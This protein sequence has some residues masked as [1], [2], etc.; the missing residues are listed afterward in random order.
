MKSKILSLFLALSLNQASA[1][2]AKHTF[3]IGKD[4]FLLDGNPIVIRCGELHSARV[5]REYWQDRL[6]RMRAMGMNAVCAYLFWN[7]HEWEEGKYDWKGQADVAEFCR[8]AQAEGLLVV[9]RPGPYA[10][11]EWEMG[12]LPW[13]LLKDKDIEL[14]TR[15]PKFL[16]ASKSW[17]KEVGRELGPLQVTKGGPIVMVQVENEYGFYGD[18]KEYMTELARAT[19]EAGFDVPL[20]ACNPRVKIDVARIPE[21]FPVVNFGSDP[22]GAFKALREVLPEGPLMCGE[23]YPGWFDTWGY[24]HHLGNTKGYLSDLEYMLK[25]KGSFSIYMAHGGTSF[26]LWAG[27]DGPFKPD[28]S[29]YDYDA[30]ISEAGWIGEKFQKTR[31]LMSRYLEA[32]E[33]LPD[34]PANL[35]VMSVPEFSLEQSAAIFENLPTPVADRQ[36]QNMEMYDQGRGMILYRTTIPAGPEAML[37]TS[38]VH[39]F[40]WVFVDGRQIGILDRR[41]ASSKVTIPARTEPQTLDLLVE[42]MGRVN[43]GRG[44]HDRKGLNGEISLVPKKGDKVVLENW[45]VFNMDLGEKMLAGLQWK[46]GK[47][48]GP[49]F[50]RG[51]F[52]VGKTDDTFLDVSS[53]GKGVVWINGHCLGRFW[54]IGPTQTMYVPGPW[55]KKGENEVI[56]LDLIGPER[57]VLSGLEKPIL[58]KLH[59]EKDFNKP[60]LLSKGKLLLDGLTPQWEATFENKDEAQTVRFGKTLE[61]RQLALEMLNSQD[62][63]PFA[64]IS[65]LDLLDEHGKPLPQANWRIVYAD[66]EELSAEDGSAANTINGQV[67]DFWHTAWSATKAPYPHRLILDLGVQTRIGG[68]RYT[69]RPGMKQVGRLKDYRIYVGDTLVETP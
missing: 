31:E 6:R 25:N 7:F 64:V 51:T 67:S 30:P 56:V 16:E 46:K 13:W 8:L 10:C 5:P 4:A 55:L 38:P 15:D 34:A 11:A 57:P 29:S 37:N 24:P 50:W 17:I 63:G 33:K 28:T 32:G 52:Q 60:S 45:Q 47:A 66:S 69:P 42:A 21:L 20:F 22:E 68:I 48:M 61:G 54:A 49:A 19:R 3:E 2:E 40:G 43:F 18:D 39:D 9:L 12:G 26:G 36:V 53:W 35:P 23:F 44:V 62:G 59:P 1:A 58:D 65:E 14:R 27:A 41:R